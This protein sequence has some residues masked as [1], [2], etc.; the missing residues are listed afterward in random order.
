MLPMQAGL[1]ERR[2]SRKKPPDIYF[3]DVRYEYS[4]KELPLLVLSGEVQTPNPLLVLEYGFFR[5]AKSA[6]H[7]TTA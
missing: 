7:V 5:I 2:D 1:V 3:E 6:R 4:L